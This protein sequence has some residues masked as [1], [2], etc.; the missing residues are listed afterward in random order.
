V[1]RRTRLQIYVVIAAQLLMAIPAMSSAFVASTLHPAA[2]GGMAR[3]EHGDHCPCCPDGVTT[4]ADCLASCTLAAAIPPV[5]M[6]VTPVTLS[7]APAPE[8]PAITSHFDDPPLE[9][10]PIR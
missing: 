7:I 4:M 5:M 3:A 9:P 2:C 10:P 8:P 6:V 1:T